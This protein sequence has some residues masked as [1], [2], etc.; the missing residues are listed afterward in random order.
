MSNYEW[1]ELPDT[2]RTYEGRMLAGTDVVNGTGQCWVRFWENPEPDSGEAVFFSMPGSEVR[3]LSAYLANVADA[4]DHA[5]HQEQCGC[6]K[7]DCQ[8]RHAP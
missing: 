7:A 2:L 5:Y 8:Y 1:Q 3:A 4:A 6:E